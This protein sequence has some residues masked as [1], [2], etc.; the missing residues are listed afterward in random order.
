MPDPNDVVGVSGKEGLT[1][2]RPGQRGDIGLLTLGAD[3]VGGEGVDNVL[4]LQIPNLDVG[5]GSSAQP[6]AIGAEGQGLDAV[7]RIQG[8]QVLA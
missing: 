5:S 8:V 2:S 7:A 6:V 1:I 4:A 3:G